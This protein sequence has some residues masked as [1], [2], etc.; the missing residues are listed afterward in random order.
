MRTRKSPA[1]FGVLK[2]SLRC[3]CLALLALALMA[4]CAPT[5]PV[6]DVPP[7]DPNRTMPDPAKQ[8]QPGKEAGG[9]IAPEGEIIGR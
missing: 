8:T 2:G 6:A 9:P 1:A 7:T 5:E 4:G 3:L